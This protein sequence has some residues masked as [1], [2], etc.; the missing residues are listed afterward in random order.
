MHKV[1]LVLGCLAYLGSGQP[2]PDGISVFIATPAYGGMVNAEYTLAVVN[3]VTTLKEVTWHLE[4]TG[5][6]SI[7]TVGRNNLVMEFLASKCTHMLFLD[8]D[9][10]VDV[11]TVKGLLALDVDIALAPYPVKNLNEQQIQERAGRTGNPPRLRDGLH[12]NLHVQPPKFIEAMEK[13]SRYVEVDAGPTGCML[14][15]RGVFDRMIVAYPDLHAKVVGSKEGKPYRYDKWWRFFDTL[16]TDEGDFLGE[17]IAFC[18]LWRN[19]GGLIYADMQA[20]L[21]HVGRQAFRGSL[22]E[23]LL[24]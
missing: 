20:A 14:I 9:L 16:V 1:T 19:I 11:E 6:Q 5:G 17:D 7:V 21:T 18:R 24:T 10:Q 22:E 15:K 23:F 8:A 3:I 4:L 2:L 13:G 12:F